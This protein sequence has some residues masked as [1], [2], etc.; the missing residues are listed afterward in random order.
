MG[1]WGGG[2]ASE[3]ARGPGTETWGNP[4]G[5][6]VIRRDKFAEMILGNCKD[7]SGKNEFKTQELSHV[8]TRDLDLRVRARYEETNSRETKK[9]GI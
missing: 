9:R 3:G 1:N 8:L 4:K 2:L 5:G 7:P 6:D